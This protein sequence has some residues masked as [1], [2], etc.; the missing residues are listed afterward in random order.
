MI[1][2]QSYFFNFNLIFFN[3]TLLRLKKINKYFDEISNNLNIYFF[4]YQKK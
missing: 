2:H 4:F 1:T 3:L